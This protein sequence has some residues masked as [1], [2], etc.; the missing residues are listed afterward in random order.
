MSVR[1]NR[2]GVTIGICGLESLSL[3]ETKLQVGVCEGSMN[4]SNI[5][6]KVAQ[7]DLIKVKV[8]S[9]VNL[10]RSGLNLVKIN[11]DITEVRNKHPTNMVTKKK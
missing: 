1:V 2:K 3:I 11:L 7:D 9:N 6:N 5:K 10:F 4:E 8:S